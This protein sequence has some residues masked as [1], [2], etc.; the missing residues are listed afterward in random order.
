MSANGARSGGGGVSVEQFFDVNDVSDGSKVEATV[1][2]LAAPGAAEESTSAREPETTETT[3]ATPSRRDEPMQLGPGRGEE[4]EAPES[5]LTDDDEVEDDADYDEVIKGLTAAAQAERKARQEIQA[6]YEKRIEELAEDR[7]FR[8]KYEPHVKE[9][10]DLWPEIEAQSAE[11]NQTKREADLYKK[12]L[13]AYRKEAQEVGITVDER[14]FL[15]AAER[16]ETKTLLKSL[17]EIIDQR[18]SRVFDSKAEHYSRLDAERE[19]QARADEAR[20]Q[21][22][23]AVARSMSSLYEKHPEIQDFDRFIRPEVEKDPT[24]DP[25]LVAAPFLKITSAGKA[26]ARAKGATSGVKHS[27][28]GEARQAP[29]STQNRDFSSEFANMGIDAQYALLKRKGLL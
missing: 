22:N 10:S 16:E 26:K 7:A 29:K 3:E 6:A 1:G 15:E 21:W 4:E 5:T 20:N 14:A 19:R 23:A 9:L 27:G 8:E 2:G 18:I 13:D 24:V 17:P 12:M 25:M 11:L 28:S